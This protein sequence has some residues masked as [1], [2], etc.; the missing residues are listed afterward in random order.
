VRTPGVRDGI[1]LGTVGALWV[2]VVTAIG[3][4]LA[5]LPFPP[6]DLFDGEAR[7]LPGA[8][9]GFTVETIVALARALDL[10]PTAT[11][12]KIAEHAVALL[13]FLVLGALVGVALVLSVRRRPALG[14][15]VGVLVGAACA[16]AFA[17]IRGAL[18]FAVSPAL[19][20]AWLAVVLTG[21]GAVMGI[22]VRGA[23]GEGAGRPE[24]PAGPSRRRIL[25]WTGLAGLAAAL[26]L[27][28]AAVRRRGGAA[29]AARGASS[30]AEPPPPETSGPAV[31]PDE[32]TLAARIEPAPGTR[33]EVT[34][35]GDFYRV[36]ID[37]LPPRIDASRWRLQVGG[38]VA[39]PA[40]LSLDD[41]RALPSVTQ[42][43]TLSC[44]SNPVGG[45]LIS[46]GFV[47]GVPVREL[48][49]RVE[50]RAE[51]TALNMRCAD[52]F[53][54]SL[55]LAT[56]MDAR[57]LLVHALDGA[58]LPAE[59]GAPARIYIPGRYGMKQ[60][61][62]ITSIELSDQALTG[63][64]VERGWDRDAFVRTTS[65]VDAPRDTVRAAGPVAVGG[66]A[67]SGE[68]GISRV[69]I[70]VDGGDWQPATLR[71]PPLSPL[72]WVQWRATLPL[73][74]GDHTIGVRAYDGSGRLQVTTPSDTAPSGATGLFTRSVTVRV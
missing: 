29:D 49:A 13:Q 36:D 34:P 32:R 10:G 5:G 23:A 6:F 50:P 9:V 61:K 20:V 56:A 46:T 26:G 66:I 4:L 65:V 55:A 41:L 70:Q 17:L 8:V 38:L 60:P 28:A 48:L 47:T 59:H 63:Y 12:A 57:T 22:W 21:G 40:S 37:S 39:R 43:I 1:V 11:V 53:Y 31:S 3:L 74:P 42:A 54:E 19:A 73:A 30:P 72:T 44:I 33:P 51:A 71:I 18:G 45:D 27:A 62:W 69:E 15:R 35:V 24:T 52:G 68:R 7:V 58:P 64:W 67:Y 14:P 25:Y 16:L 2:A